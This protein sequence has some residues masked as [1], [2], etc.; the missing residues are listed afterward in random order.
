MQVPVH[1]TVRN[2]S[3]SSCP[4]QPAPALCHCCERIAHHTQPGFCPPTVFWRRFN[5]RLRALR[6][7][8][9]RSRAVDHYRQGDTRR[10]I[11]RCTCCS[12]AYLLAVAQLYFYVLP[13]ATVTSPGI[14]FDHCDTLTVPTL[15]VSHRISHCVSH[16]HH[17]LLVLL[18]PFTHIRP[19]P[20][21]DTPYSRGCQAGWSAL[22]PVPGWPGRPVVVHKLAG[23]AHGR[24]GPRPQA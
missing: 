24:S 4:C 6:T 14:L 19:F 21:H 8:N 17:H 20:S 22:H 16:S 2:I 10:P 11:P 5:H 23:L 1:P 18:V 13:T 15:S 9:P 7:T 12:S 3:C